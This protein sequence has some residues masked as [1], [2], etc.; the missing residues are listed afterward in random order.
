MVGLVTAPIMLAAVS[1]VSVNAAVGPVRVIT[2]PAMA[3]PVRVVPTDVVTAVLAAKNGDPA[4]PVGR[5]GKMTILML[6][7][8]PAVANDNEMPMIHWLE[9]DDRFAAVPYPL[10]DEITNVF[11]AIVPT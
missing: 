5:Y 2:P 3:A 10:V 9:P 4:V 11:G 6:Q 1:V 8:W 7:D